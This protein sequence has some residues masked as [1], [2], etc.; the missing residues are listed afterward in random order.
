MSHNLKNYIKI[1]GLALACTGFATY[2]LLN[3]KESTIKSS[4]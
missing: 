1:G 3:K 4:S 2:F